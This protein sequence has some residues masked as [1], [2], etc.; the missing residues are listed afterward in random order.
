MTVPASVVDQKVPT[1]TIVAATPHGALAELAS[2][3]ARL[4]KPVPASVVAEQ[5][6]AEPAAPTVP[7]GAL[8]ELAS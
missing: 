2:S 5:V 4:P 6:P 3:T 7:H 8:A 1:A